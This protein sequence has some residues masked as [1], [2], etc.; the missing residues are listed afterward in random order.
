MVKSHLPSRGFVFD[1]NPSALHMGSADPDETLLWKEGQAEAI[2]N[3]L[4][5]G[6]ADESE[7]PEDDGPEGGGEG[8]GQGEERRSRAQSKLE[9]RQSS[10][11]SRSM[12]RDL[13]PNE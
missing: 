7:E 2:E 11:P 10:V 5:E 12:S 3:E 6:E 8:Q 13:G 4:L 9:G 1:A